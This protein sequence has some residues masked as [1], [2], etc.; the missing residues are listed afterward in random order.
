MS[1]KTVDILNGKVNNVMVEYFILQRCH[2]E[3]VLM[4]L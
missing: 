1:T 2:Q 4:H 3:K